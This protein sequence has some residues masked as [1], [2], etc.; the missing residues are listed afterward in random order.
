[1]PFISTKTNKH[2]SAEDTKAL[3][4][5]YGRAIELLPGKTEEWLM[6][7]FEG[8][9]PM[10]FRGRSGTDMAFLSVSLVGKAPRAAYDALTARLCEIMADT[11]GIRPDMT[12]VKYE[13]VDCWGYDGT[14]F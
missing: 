4:E 11:L 14:N 12:Y 9:T 3:T 6:L 7:S 10:A 1:M 8:D 2:L 5:A 13:E